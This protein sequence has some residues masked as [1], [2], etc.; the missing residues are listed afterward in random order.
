MWRRAAISMAAMLGVSAAFVA[1]V[2]LVLGSIVDMA[3]APSS[4]GDKAESAKSETAT[5]AEDKSPSVKS[6]GPEA[7]G[8]Q[9]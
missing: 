6:K 7:P 2:M 5:G 4:T 8:E 1:V 9:S 3:V